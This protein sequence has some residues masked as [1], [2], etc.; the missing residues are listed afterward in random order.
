MTPQFADTN[1]K[2]LMSES[3]SL[4]TKPEDIV[5]ALVERFNSGKISELMP[6]YE[7]EVV[8]VKPDGRTVTGHAGIVDDLEPFLTLGLSLT[9]KTRHVFVAGDTAE[10]ILDWSIDGTGPDGEKMH[11]HGSAS[12]VLRR[13]AD[14]VWRYLIDNNQGTAVRRPA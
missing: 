4:P 3:C 1:R 13:G 11:F 12:D 8:L 7:E 14:G 6:L 10:I 9:A 2:I 5:T